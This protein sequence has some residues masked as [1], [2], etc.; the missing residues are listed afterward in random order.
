MRRGMHQTTRQRN[1]IKI[2]NLQREWENEREKGR[3][4]EPVDP[5]NAPLPCYFNTGCGLYMDGITAIEIEEDVIKLVKWSNTSCLAN[6]AKC[7][8]KAR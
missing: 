7:S 5:G 4:I 6:R 2:E 3:A 8:T 1:L